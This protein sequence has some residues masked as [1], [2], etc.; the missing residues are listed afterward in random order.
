[1]DH[2]E[3]TIFLFILEHLAL[4]GI[5]FSVLIG[6][7]LRVRKERRDEDVVA[8]RGGDRQQLA[9]MRE[10]MTQLREMMADLLIDTHDRRPEAVASEPL[11]ADTQTDR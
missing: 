3:F 4:V 11:R 2:D 5:G 9:D 7:M 1:M 6:R 8:L 10:E